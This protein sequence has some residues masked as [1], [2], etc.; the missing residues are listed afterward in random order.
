MI[1]AAKTELRRQKRGN[2]DFE[3]AAFEDNPNEMKS[4]AEDLMRIF[5]SVLEDDEGTG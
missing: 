3:A 2:K 4:G 1:E 5:G